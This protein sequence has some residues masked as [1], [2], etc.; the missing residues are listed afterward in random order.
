MRSHIIISYFIQLMHIFLLKKKKTD[1]HFTSKE[2]TCTIF[3]NIKKHMH[4]LRNPHYIYIS[5][6]N[7]VSQILI[8]QFVL[9]RMLF[10]IIQCNSLCCI[11]FLQWTKKL[12]Y[13]FQ[14]MK[15][16]MTLFFF[17]FVGTI[18]HSRWG[19]FQSV[20]ILKE[21]VMNQKDWH[22]GC[23]N[24][25]IY[26]VLLCIFESYFNNLYINKSCVRLVHINFCSGFNWMST[27]CWDRSMVSFVF[28]N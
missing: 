26:S 25:V 17:F 19:C 10:N 22:G 9:Y 1:A 7:V 14:L 2:N 18:S 24:F 13:G 21:K 3:F 12:V 23:V 16:Y 15:L 6:F 8:D 4:H 27:S 28:A 5:L 11:M 20:L